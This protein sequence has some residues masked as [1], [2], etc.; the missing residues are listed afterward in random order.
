M[1]R[2]M[3]ASSSPSLVLPRLVCTIRPSSIPPHLPFLPFLPARSQRTRPLSRIRPPPLCSRGPLGASRG[4]AGSPRPRRPAGRT[5]SPPPCTSGALGSSTTSRR[6]C[7]RPAPRP[8]PAHANK[9]PY[10]DSGAESS[11]PPQRSLS[12]HKAYLRVLPKVLD[13]RDRRLVRRRV[14]HHRRADARAGRAELGLVLCR[15]RHEPVAVAAVEVRLPGDDL[16]E[17][18]AL[19][20]VVVQRTGRAA[21]GPAERAPRVHAVHD[22]RRQREQQ[23]AAEVVVRVLD[24]HRVRLEVVVRPEL[25]VVP[26]RVHAHVGLHE[27]VLA[28]LA[29]LEHEV[30]LAA[31]A[32]HDRVRAQHDRVRARLRPRKALEDDA[33]RDRFQEHAHQR[34]QSSHTQRMLVSCVD[35]V[36][37]L[38]CRLDTVSSR[39][40]PRTS[41]VITVCIQPQRLKNTSPPFVPKPMWSGTVVYRKPKKSSVERYCRRHGGSER[42]ASAS[43]AASSSILD[44]RPHS[45]HHAQRTHQEDERAEHFAQPHVDDRVERV[46]QVQLP[47]RLDLVAADAA[48]RQYAHSQRENALPPALGALEERVGAVDDAPRARRRHRH[49][50]MQRHAGRLVAARARVA[51]LQQGLDRFGRR[52]AIFVQRVAGAALHRG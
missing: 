6:R 5:G 10:K 11:D 35:T 3:V 44:N 8:P 36:T 25:D 29:R 46:L 2:T 18:V 23:H 14:I 39:T 49:A 48:A 33:D 28:H 47:V 51:A 12:K 24:A 42:Y 21:L 52:L 50:A 41:D 16:R 7:P 4:S 27:L 37:S 31:D 45:T 32:P 26:D 40:L 30:E 43:R 9:H 13:V 1:S 22:D 34:L 38:P 20:R 19:G 15:E 17:E